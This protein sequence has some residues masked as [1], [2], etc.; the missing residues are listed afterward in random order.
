MNENIYLESAT[1]ADS[2]GIALMVGELLNEIM[3]ATGTPAFNFN[4]EETT[5]RLKGFIE[6]GRYFVLVARRRLLVR[7]ARRRLCLGSLGTAPPRGKGRAS[8]GPGS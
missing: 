8:L 7:A 1:S 5:E 6:Q 3:S 2:P 4:L